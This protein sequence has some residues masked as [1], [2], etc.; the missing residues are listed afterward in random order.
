MYQRLMRPL[1]WAILG[2]CSIS[3]WAQGVDTATAKDIIE[4]TLG[5][6]NTGNSAI[7]LSFLILNKDGSTQ[8]E[9]AAHYPFY[10]G[11]MMRVKILS[12]QSGT[13]QLTNINAT[14][15]VT[16]MRTIPVQ[17]GT[18]AYYPPENNAVLEF[19]N[20]AGSEILRV[21]FTP[22]TSISSNS[23]WNN[24][25][26]SAYGQPNLSQSYVPS[27]GNAM[28]TSGQIM[29][30]QVSPGAAYVPPSQPADTVGNG[31]VNGGA[32]GQGGA[33]PVQGNVGY[34]GNPVGMSP[35][36]PASGHQG[37]ASGMPSRPSEFFTGVQGKA[38]AYAKDIRETVLETPNATYLVRPV[39]TGAIQFDVTIQHRNF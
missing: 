5:G 21:T 36:P 15:K 7:K 10:S 19:A 22:Q 2:I 26:P 3:A 34:S 4:R 14:G 11:E 1:A 35:V 32:Q 25:N 16:P 17:A 31:S 30:G 24:G 28:Q 29:T 8:M 20:A 37:M 6:Q 38:Y 23:N 18:P 27:L 9:R 33:Y 13:L 39:E 12:A